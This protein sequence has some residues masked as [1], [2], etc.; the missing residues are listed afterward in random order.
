MSQLLKIKNSLIS[1]QSIKSYTRRGKVNPNYIA[2]LDAPEPHH[3]PPKVEKV[4]YHPLPVIETTSTSSVYLR[5]TNLLGQSSLTGR[6][7][8]SSL[9]GEFEPSHFASRR[10]ISTAP[11]TQFQKDPSPE[12]HRHSTSHAYSKRE[13]LDKIEKEFVTPTRYEPK[14]FGDHFARY[15]VK[16]LR[17]L[18]NM[19][20]KEKYI[21]YACLLET[22]AAVPG[23]AGGM[24]QHLHSLRTCQNNY[25]IKTLLDEAENERMHL[26]TFIEIT[27]PTFGERVLIA[28]A[29]A[30][31]LVDYTILYLVSPKT[32]HRF[33]GFLE[34][35]AVLT[36]T[37]MLRDLDAGLVENVNAPAIAKAYWGLPED[38]KLRDVI[39]VIRQDEVEHAHVNHDISNT[40]ATEKVP[41]KQTT[42]TT[43]PSSSSNT[44]TLA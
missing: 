35:E 29:Q 3:Y 26:M 32:A 17:L 7:S 22:V 36:Y 20:F 4:E 28:L 10:R 37:N 14:T 12:Y 42:P 6:L 16:S 23:M 33:V 11:L 1:P 19:F 43:P 25:V 31:Y 15:A 44:A 34:E 21:H 2:F 41:S 18:S 5:G 27:K 39:M 30:A 9:F 40:L 38:A 24:L 8:A 13:H